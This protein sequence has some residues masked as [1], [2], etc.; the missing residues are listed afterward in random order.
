MTLSCTAG[1]GCTQ[2]SADVPLAA[3][4]RPTGGSSSIITLHNVPVGLCYRRLKHNVLHKT[5]PLI[6][7]AC[8]RQLKHHVLQKAPADVPHAAVQRPARGS[9][10]T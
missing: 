7:E 8:R 1:Q 2:D 10:S 5:P 6:Q 3:V 9:P 4:Q